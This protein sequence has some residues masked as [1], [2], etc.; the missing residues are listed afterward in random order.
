[1]FFE[2]VSR[3]A[4]IRA[5]IWTPRCQSDAQPTPRPRRNA[6]G[7]SLSRASAT[8]SRARRDDQATASLAA[9]LALALTDTISRFAATL[10]LR[11]VRFTCCSRGSVPTSTRVCWAA[12]SRARMRCRSAAPALLRHGAGRLRFNV[13]DGAPRDT[14]CAR[15]AAALATPPQ[16]RA[17]RFGRRRR[18]PMHGYE[19]QS[20][21]RD[22]SRSRSPP[23][24]CR[25]PR[26]SLGYKSRTIAPAP[27]RRNAPVA[28]GTFWPR[29]STRTA[30][31]HTAAAASQTSA[32]STRTSR[33]SKWSVPGRAGDLEHAAQSSALRAHVRRCRQ[34]RVIRAADEARRARRLRARRERRRSRAGRKRRRGCRC[35]GGRARCVQCALRS[36]RARCRRQ[37]VTVARDR[38][39]PADE[40]AH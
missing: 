11:I 35:G 28:L 12:P 3:D 24:H 17:A 14:A 31:T 9:N 32:D 27:P 22:C 13:Y 26:V 33:M 2:V 30:T 34:R 6:V 29:R 16:S 40:T 25:F 15:A 18:R 10:A 37:T 23:A 39:A 21:V 4:V 7:S 38:Q 20:A 5:P 19:I 1:M 36:I 8:G